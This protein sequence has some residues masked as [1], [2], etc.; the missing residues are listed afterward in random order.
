MKMCYACT[1]NDD[2]VIKFCN[3]NYINYICN[4]RRNL[5]HNYSLD[6]RLVPNANQ[7]YY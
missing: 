2:S 3:T 4:R 1:A 7:N 6:G 5:P